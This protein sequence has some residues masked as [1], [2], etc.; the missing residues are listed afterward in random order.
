[1]ENDNENKKLIKKEWI[2]GLVEV[3]VEESE[4]DIIV[5]VLRGDEQ[6]IDRELVLKKKKI[7]MLNNKKLRV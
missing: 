6:Q 7:Y 2:C 5:K 3:V 4:V 1:M